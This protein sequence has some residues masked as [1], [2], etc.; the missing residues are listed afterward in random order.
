MG[1]KKNIMAVGALQALVDDVDK[2]WI[3]PR[4]RVSFTGIEVII[5]RK[6]FRE[7]KHSI[8]VYLQR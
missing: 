7:M 2:K 3:M 5:F 8:G 4:V 6:Q 1:L